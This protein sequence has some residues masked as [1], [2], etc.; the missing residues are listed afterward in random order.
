MIGRSRDRAAIAA[1][2]AA[3]L[4][5]V[6]AL[7]SSGRAQAAV[8]FSKDVAP[9]LYEHCATCHRPGAI[10]PF[11]LLTYDDARPQARALALVTRERT[12]P[13]WKPEPG[14]GDFTGEDRLTD[15]QI[16]IIQQWVDG[17]AVQGDPSML[18]PAP[19]FADGWRLGQPDLVVTLK[20]PFVLGAG[21]PDVLR[22]FVIPIPTQSMKYVR[23]IEFRPGN[24]RVV[25]H[26]NMRIDPTSSSRLL[27]DADPEPGFSGLLVSGSFPDG[28]FLGWTP[29]Q[30]PPLLP[31]GM[32]W[33]LEPGSDLVVQL[34]MHPGNSPETIQPSVG[35]FFTDTP[36]TR[37]PVMLRLGRQNID[38]PAGASHYGVSDEYRLPIDVEILAVQP[39]AHY[40]ARQIKGT[41]TLPDGT[42]K[43][44]ILIK[45]WDFNWQDL[46]RYREPLKVPK[47]TTLSMEFTYD[48]SAANR[49][50]PDRPTQHV[51]WGQNS[52]DEMGD[53]WLQVV[54]SSSSDRKILETDFGPK[55]IGEDAVGYETLLVTDPNNARLHDAVA[56]LLLGLGQPARAMAHLEEALRIDPNLASAHYNLASAFLAG[57][58]ANA[59]VDHLRRAVELSPAFAAAHVNLGTALRQLRRYDES[60]RELRRGLELQP[61]SAPAHTNLAGV[62]ASQGHPR[63]AIA[64]Y[65]LAL[66]LAPDLLEPMASLAWMLATTSDPTVRR[67]AEAIRLAE[68]AASLTGR[69]DVTILDAL[70]AAY[71]SAGRYAEAVAT[72]QS[73]L[74][75]VEKAGAVSAAAPIRERLELYRKKRPYVN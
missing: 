75:I 67:P 12:M 74:E 26:A 43:P 70:A 57:N 14:F 19:H 27:D 45:D 62:L 42:T 32:S 4:F 51:R 23:G 46:Y 21:G 71:A 58:D 41:A 55:V 16:G 30:L 39:H 11:S 37:A 2:T 47:G 56:A 73:A 9:I 69:R 48:N 13:P 6:L 1:R 54:A 61:R 7:A 25:H 20:S 59:A 50:N 15:R 72:E 63:E 28:F 18:P 65:R 44:L 68:R 29:G 53:L 64:E 5:G 60:E 49:R 33:R 35:L 3:T 34:H 10:A 36:P 52:N 40:R 22:N 24:T 8:T 17:G 66:E 38:I 31:N